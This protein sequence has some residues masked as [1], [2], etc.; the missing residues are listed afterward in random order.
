MFSEARID[1]GMAQT[2]AST[3]PQRAICTVTSISL[4]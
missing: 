4:R 1:S 3:V 2:I